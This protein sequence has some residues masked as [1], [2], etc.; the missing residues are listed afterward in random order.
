MGEEYTRPRSIKTARS[1]RQK[2]RDLP[3][4]PLGSVGDNLAAFEQHLWARPAAA[5]TVERYMT[6]ARQFD[7]FVGGADIT[8]LGRD[9]IEKFNVHQMEINSPVTAA[10]KFISLRQFFKFMGIVAAEQGIE[11]KNPTDGMTA[12]LY[13]Q[14][15]VEVIPDAFLARLIADAERGTHVVNHQ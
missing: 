2:L 12:P 9:H 15:V 8:I 13:E 14:P 1:W 6:D 7:A 3:A 4:E 11:F 5:K 10:T